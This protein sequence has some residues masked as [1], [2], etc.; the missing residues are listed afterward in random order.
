MAAQAQFD[1]G[2]QTQVRQAQLDG[3]LADA[4]LREGREGSGRCSCTIPDMSHELCQTET[5][6]Q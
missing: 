5:S 6:K 3:G 4:P 1:G 2:R